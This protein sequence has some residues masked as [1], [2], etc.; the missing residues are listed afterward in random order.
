MALAAATG[1]GGGGSG[2]GS[3]GV[4]RWRG[5][6][7]ACRRLGGGV[8]SIASS[9]SLPLPPPPTAASSRSSSP[10]LRSSSPS[11]CAISGST[12][13]RSDPG[14]AAERQAAVLDDL[15]RRRSRRSR[16]T[17]SRTSSQEA[18]LDAPL[19]ILD[20][21]LGDFGG[22]APDAHALR[23][24]RLAF[25]LAVPAEPDTIAPAWP[26]CLPAGAVN[27]AM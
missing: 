9:I 6:G 17:R 15:G 20:G 23:F 21:Q 11:V 19:S 2:R 7:G 12:A 1:V 13:K 24:Q 18:G 14:D 5:W 10:S 26:I 25:A 4:G 27:P 8:G 3:G 16:T 22:G